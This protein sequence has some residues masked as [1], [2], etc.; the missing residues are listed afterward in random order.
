[1]PL[2]SVIYHPL[3][4][5]IIIFTFLY[6]FLFIIIFFF[7]S[8]FIPLSLLFFFFFFNDT[9]PPEISPLSLHDALPI[10]AA[11]APRPQPPA[12][13]VGRGLP[14]GDLPSLEPGRLRRD[15]RHRR[16]A[17]GRSALGERH[18]EAAL[19]NGVDRARAIPRRA[20]HV[21][22]S[23]RGAPDDPPAPDPRALSHAA[24]GLRLGRRARRSGAAGARRVRRA[25]R[26]DAE[27]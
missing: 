1:M 18:G 10:Y 3:S 11:N 7:F 27:P 21:A 25:D 20:A 9:A 8:L 24:P 5:I 14:Q 15:Q 2:I 16:D 17:R 6:F 4:P 26:A 19:R 22:G 12:H 23:A 13:P